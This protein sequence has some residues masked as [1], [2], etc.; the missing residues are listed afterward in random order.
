MFKKFLENLRKSSSVSKPLLVD[1]IDESDRTYNNISVIDE[2]KAFIE[3]SDDTE[4]IIKAYRIL[5]SIGENCD[6]TDLTNYFILQAETENNE[7]IKDWIYS[8]I[9]WQKKTEE[10][11]LKPILKTLYKYRKG[12]IVDP[13]IECLKNSK[14]Q[15]AED[16]LIYAL[17]NYTSEFTLIQTNVSL[18]TAGTRKS[19]PFLTKKLNEKSQ[20]LVGS[21]FLAIITL[22]DERESE[23][24][25]NHLLHGKDRH[26][27][28]EGIYRHCG[29]EAISAVMERL[30]KKTAIARKSDCSCFFYP[31][32]ND[33]TLG[34]KF[35]GRYKLE[36]P[37]IN[38]FFKFMRNSRWEKLY[39]YE[40]VTL[41]EQME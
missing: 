4:R 31:N 18:H 19:I 13:I 10:V 33:T 15:D 30:K 26:S 1:T 20:D 3:T 5:G 12:N 21:A 9:G 2:L 32:D 41:V 39:D 38:D 27:A 16:A 24:F 25:I 37:E 28:M 34:L 8:V 6:L 36:H 7:K 14:N 29:P 11:D 40:Q 22:G 17:E 35:L 23:L